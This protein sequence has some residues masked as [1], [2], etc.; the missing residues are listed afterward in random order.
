L[1]RVRPDRVPPFL[2]G[3]VEAGNSHPIGL[4][5]V[6]FLPRE[7]RIRRLDVVLERT[8]PKMTIGRQNCGE[9]KGNPSHS[10]ANLFPPCFF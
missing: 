9:N 8:R 6:L 1:E 10:I 3:Q 4:K 5:G 2:G 7:S